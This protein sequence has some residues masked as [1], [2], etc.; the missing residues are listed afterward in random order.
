MSNPNLRRRCRSTEAQDSKQTSCISREGR[1]RRKQPRRKEGKE[2]PGE[3]GSKYCERPTKQ[4]LHLLHSFE[5][6]RWK[7]S[8]GLWPNGV[9]DQFCSSSLFVTPFIPQGTL[10]P[11]SRPA[12]AL[13][14]RSLDPAKGPRAPGSPQGDPKDPPGTPQG[15]PGTLPELP[16]TP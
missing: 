7:S 11:R 13:P 2:E 5:V 4:D 6:D 8:P 12:R 1:W 14:G 3:S 15:T 16:G 9:I 10:G